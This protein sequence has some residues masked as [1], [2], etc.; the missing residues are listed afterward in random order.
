MFEAKIIADSICNGQRLTTMQVT[1]PRIILAE[2]N[3][4]C[5]FARNTS[6]S[7]AIP[8]SKMV[9]RVIESPFVPI[10][11]GCNQGGMQ[12]FEE[13]QGL[14][15][16]KAIKLWLDAR[17]K[18]VE[19]ATEL[20]SES[21]TACGGDGKARLLPSLDDI[22]LYA[23][24]IKAAAILSDDPC[25]RCGGDG[26]GL[27][28][29]KQIVNRLLE[30]WMWTTNCTTGDAGAWSN[31]FALR[32]EKD[33]EPHIQRAA[34]MA[35][36]AYFTSTP[37]VLEPGQWHTPYIR[38]EE[39]QQI[40]EWAWEQN[41]GIAVYFNDLAKTQALAKKIV[42]VSTGRCARTSYLT[43]EGTRD[44]AKD[45][46]LHDRLR[47]HVPLHASPFEHVCQAMDDDQRYGK[48]TG[49]K[50]Y[51]HMLPREYVTDFK[52]NHPELVNG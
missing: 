48:Y 40:A 36:K 21:C 3:T 39:R 16:E 26:L 5:M 32:C 2:W 27:N 34:Y 10:H 8:F 22:D 19:I 6:S 25:P 41:K 49:W 42:E 13:L 37:E 9:K 46:E 33:A 35:Q 18:A 24:P 15:R 47:Y 14:P 17:D 51:R 23:E 45:I 38:P 4:H 11:W 7:R 12:A 28:V 44:F 20:A 50:S 52:P 30:P 29:H 31:F 1:F 43:Q